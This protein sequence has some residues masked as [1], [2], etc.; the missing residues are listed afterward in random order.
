MACVFKARIN[1]QF[2][3]PGNLKGVAGFKLLTKLDPYKCRS[4][5]PTTSA[6]SFNRLSKLNVK[7]VYGS[8]TNMVFVVTTRRAPVNSIGWLAR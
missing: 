3:R 1:P 8:L 7:S 6:F 4:K 2:H 5:C